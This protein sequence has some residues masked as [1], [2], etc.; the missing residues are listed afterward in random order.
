MGVGSVVLFI[1]AAL[2]VAG[3]GG[4]ADYLWSSLGPAARLGVLLAAFAAQSGLALAL[5]TRLAGVAA[6]LGATGAATLLFAAGGRR[7]RS[8]RT[9]CVASRSLRQVLLLSPQPGSS[10]GA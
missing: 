7:W 4:F 9:W 10:S 6:A 3:L 8:T 2:A 5:R 1:G